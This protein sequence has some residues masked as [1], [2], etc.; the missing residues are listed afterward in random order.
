VWAW[1]R[2]GRGIKYNK[3]RGRFYILFAAGVRWRADQLAAGSGSEV[4]P[5]AVREVVDGRRPPGS[6]HLLA[7]HWS[8]AMV[9]PAGLGV[10]VAP[11]PGPSSIARRGMMVE[12]GPPRTL[13]E[14]VRPTPH[15]F[16]P[17]LVAVDVLTHL[18]DFDSLDLKQ[19][20]SL[21]N[22]TP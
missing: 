2:D 3:I 14:M 9:G 13:P 18:W 16:S 4:G 11:G 17:L 7:P 5:T 8:R 21:V 10:V 22:S 12:W 20:Q 19:S 6:D 15:D 1:P